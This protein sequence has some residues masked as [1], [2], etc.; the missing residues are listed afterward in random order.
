MESSLHLS[1]LGSCYGWSRITA[2]LW[3][4]SFFDF[5]AQLSAK[6]CNLKTLFLT[7]EYTDVYIKVYCKSSVCIS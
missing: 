6:L 2:S 5:V 3:K 4:G 7:L 1:F